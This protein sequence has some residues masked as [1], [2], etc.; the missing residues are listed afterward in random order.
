M[1]TQEA[2]DYLNVSR[3]YFIKL[4]DK[5]KIPYHKTGNRRKVLTSDIV[6]YKNKLKLSREKGLEKLTALSQ[7]MEGDRY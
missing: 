4:L 3:P 5:K 2:A 6:T 1:T 7:E